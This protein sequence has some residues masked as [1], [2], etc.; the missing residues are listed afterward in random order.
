[1]YSQPERDLDNYKEMQ[2]Q[3]MQKMEHQLKKQVR[4]VERRCRFGTIH[5]GMKSFF[6]WNNVLLQDKKWGSRLQEIQEQHES[7]KNRVR[8]V[9]CR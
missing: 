3:A 5:K 6:E 4:G 8:S 1:M 2:T 9:T 7:E